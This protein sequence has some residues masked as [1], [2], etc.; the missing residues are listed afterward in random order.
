[1]F[2]S[3]E[4]KMSLL[5]FTASVARRLDDLEHLDYDADEYKNLQEIFRREIKIFKDRGFGNF[6]TITDTNLTFLAEAA[7]GD[8]QGLEHLWK[9]QLKA[10]SKTIAVAGGQL[11]ALPWE[12][13]VFDR[14]DQ[15]GLAIPGARTTLEMPMEH[16][17]D[18]LNARETCL[19]FF[20]GSF[21]SIADM[22]K[23]IKRNLPDLLELDR[24]FSLEVDFSR[25]EGRTSYRRQAQEAYSG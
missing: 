12:K 13:L 5:D 11:P 3:Q 25:R 17:A 22:R 21:Y 10:R 15:G 23:I 4:H 6:D 2:K 14:N 16:I 20:P 1:M 8:A 19:T 7:A 18:N 24:Y 9:R